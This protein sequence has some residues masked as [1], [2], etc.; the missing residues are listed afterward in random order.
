MMPRYFFM[1]FIIFWSRNV[2]CATPW[3]TYVA[4]PSSEHARIVT[5]P[6][7]G[8]A[9]PQHSDGPG[10]LEQ[11]LRVL[12]AQIRA[13]DA[14]AF[15]LALRL[16]KSSSVDGALG[17]FL[18]FTVSDFL[19]VHPSAFLTGLSIY[20]THNCVEAVYTDPDVFSDRFAAQAYEFQ[21]RLD[22]IGAVRSKRLASIRDLCMQTLRSEIRTAQSHIGSP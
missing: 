5:E 16:R 20:G 22:A 19:R 2:M 3:E 7:Y 17:E 14:D 12:G 8:D 21:R 10:R 6:R 15:H 11:D 1:L 4:V 9:E 13:G 18:D